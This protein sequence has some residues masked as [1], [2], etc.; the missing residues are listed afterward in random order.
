MTAKALLE[1]VGHGGQKL[2]VFPAAVAE[3]AVVN[4]LVQRVGDA[5]GGGEVHIGDGEGQQVGG[6]KAVRDV[7]PL[8]TPGA[9]AIHDG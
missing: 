7:I 9:V 1:P 4:A 6:A 8:R 2:I 5:G 3:H